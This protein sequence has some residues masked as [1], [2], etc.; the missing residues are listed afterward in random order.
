M[1]PTSPESLALAGGVFIIAPPGNPNLIDIHGQ[2][3]C[4]FPPVRKEDFVMLQGALTPRRVM[5]Q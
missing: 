1:E 3:Q 5:P 4:L 2:R